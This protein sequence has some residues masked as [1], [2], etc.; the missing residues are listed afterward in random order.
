VASM[1]GAGGDAVAAAALRA[2]VAHTA[3]SPSIDKYGSVHFT[4]MF[5]IFF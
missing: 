4:V 3:A 5:V 2:P 1:N